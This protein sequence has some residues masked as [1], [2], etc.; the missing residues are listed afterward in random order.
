MFPLLKLYHFTT[1]CKIMK[2]TS[3]KGMAIVAE[4]L[5]SAWR[6]YYRNAQEHGEYTTVMSKKVVNKSSSDFFH[7][8]EHGKDTTVMG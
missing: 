6:G 3:S 1:L 2:N 8:K 4:G 5:G 7:V